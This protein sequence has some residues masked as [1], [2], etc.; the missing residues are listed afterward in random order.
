MFK[1]VWGLG[2]QQ[3]GDALKV[4]RAVFVCEQGYD[5]NAEFDHNDGYAAHV[6]VSDENDAPIASG[7]MYPD[8]DRILMDRIAVMPAFRA[9]PYDELVL[10]VML[11]KAQQSQMREIAA[12]VYEGGEALYLPF[13]FKKAGDTTLRGL[14][15]ALLTVP[16][17]SVIWDSACKHAE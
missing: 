14:P 3:G 10:R 2:L 11:Y 6:F 9:L 13:G 17:E 15:A 16:R 5:E 8:G 4:R 1:T 12:A 7:R